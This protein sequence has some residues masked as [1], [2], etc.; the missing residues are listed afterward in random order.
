M[1]KSS[2][3]PV[4]SEGESIQVNQGMECEGELHTNTTSPGQQKYTTTVYICMWNAL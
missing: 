4:A 2:H 1:V 3:Q